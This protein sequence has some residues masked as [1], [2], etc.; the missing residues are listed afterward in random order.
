MRRLGFDAIYAMLAS[1]RLSA[2]LAGELLADPSH[3]RVF[4]GAIE[5][6]LAL[7]ISPRNRGRVGL[8][9]PS[10]GVPR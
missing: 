8:R 6:D 3:V 1:G 9:G 2:D 10:I 5:A 4:P 7:P